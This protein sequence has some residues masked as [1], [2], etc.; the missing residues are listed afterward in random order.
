MDINIVHV[1]GSIMG[2]QGYSWVLGVVHVCCQHYSSIFMLLMFVANIVHMCYRCYSS[3]FNIVLC[4]VGA[5]N[6]A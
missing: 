2:F 6:F 1:F 5:I 4:V 3:V